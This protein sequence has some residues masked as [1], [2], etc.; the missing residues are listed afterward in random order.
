MLLRASAATIK[1]FLEGQNLFLGGQ[2]FW[3][4]L[5]FYEFSVDLKKKRSSCHFRLFFAEFS[6]DLKKKVI[7]PGVWMGMLSILGG[8]NFCLKG[9]GPLLRSASVTALLRAL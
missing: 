6:V 1:L 2:N 8:Q 9:R 5:F 4:G 3:V 7:S